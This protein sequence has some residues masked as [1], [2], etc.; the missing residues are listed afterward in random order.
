MKTNATA[1]LRLFALTGAACL[2]TA[3]SHAQTLSLGSNRP[4]VA[5]NAGFLTGLNRRSKLTLA[6]TTLPGP[7]FNGRPI[8]ADNAGFETGFNPHTICRSRAPRSL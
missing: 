5:V 2:V 4:G 8:A 1:T 6:G 7:N 3:S